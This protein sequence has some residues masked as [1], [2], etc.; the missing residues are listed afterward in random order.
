MGQFL[1]EGKRRRQPDI[2]APFRVPPKPTASRRASSAPATVK[3]RA[4]VRLTLPVIDGPQWN[5]AFY[6][7]G[8]VDYEYVVPERRM[9]QPV[10]DE[11]V[12]E[13]EPSDLGYRRDQAHGSFALINF[14]YFENIGIDQLRK[15][16]AKWPPQ[17]V[18]PNEQAFLKFLRARKVPNVGTLENLLQKPSR[19]QSG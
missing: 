4:Q 19:H 11:G 7:S 13:G 2:P 15:I 14:I 1:G 5:T 3:P 17:N 18:A 16:N 6:T 10:N 12:I 8:G 9:R